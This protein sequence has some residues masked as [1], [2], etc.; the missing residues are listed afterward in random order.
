MNKKIG[1]TFLVILAFLLLLLI[2]DS[3]LSPFLQPLG[4]ELKVEKFSSEEDF[5]IYLEEAES[6]VAGFFGGA[7]SFTVAEAPDAWEQ[8]AVPNLALEE[9]GKGIGESGR[10]S[11]TTVQVLGIDEPDIVKTDGE[12]I[13]F[14]PQSV[15]YPITLWEEDYRTMTGQ[16]RII[17][18][19]PPSELVQ[20]DKIEKSGDLLLS[21]SIL[22]IFSGDTMF[23][24]D[25]SDSQSPEKKWEV[26]FGER[27]YLDGARLYQ[28]KIYLIT[29]TSID[30]YN[31]C[32]IYPLG[33]L[34]VR[35]T[36]IY[37]PTV[38]I[39]ADITY[40]AMV[41]DPSSGEIEKTVSFVGTSSSSVVYM[42]ENSLYLVY[43]Y[44]QDF[45]EFFSDFIGENQDLFPAQLVEKMNK[46]ETYDISDMAKMTE[47]EVIFEEYTNS[48]SR[49]DEM[50][51][52]NELENRMDDYYEKHKRSFEKTG[53]VKVGLE[54][55]RVEATGSVP[56]QPL[57]QF[58][59]DEYKGYLR[60]ATTAGQ[61][62]GE[63]ANDVYILDDNLKITGQ[64]LDLGLT[65][66]IYSVRFIQDRGYV[67][68]FRQIDPFYVL[69]LSDAKNPELKGELK[70]P[71]Y[72]SYLHPVSEGKILGIGKE[73][74]NVK[75]SLFD[76]ADPEQPLEAAKYT[77]KEYWSDILDT[78]HAFLLDEKHQV[79]FLPGS[80]GGYVFSY[81]ED[82]LA[83]VRA[84]SDISARRAV[85]IDDYLY[86]IGDNKISVLDETSWEKV[87]ELDLEF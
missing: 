3:E 29:K 14:S 45:F 41:L 34:E 33:G 70:I 37:Y 62:S 52:E 85:Y 51:L 87:K 56:G 25:V 23:G 27:S 2:V 17:K 6:T 78:H 44:Y 76:V 26:D 57:N 49:D 69:D 68:T 60:M 64:V 4:S 20:K 32:P 66:R 83:M 55:F 75:V 24:Y 38:K 8:P 77:L 30:R 46:L 80:R 71:G 81:K 22:V 36:D 73:G 54:S 58:S 43:S 65:E 10:V 53:I 19:F 9:A 31:P 39:P 15:Y 11:Q 74:S 47:F 82:K 84:V 67:V 28:G 5:K 63:S 61:M 79:F 18:A 16:T 21:G 40:N 72:S 50:K 1:L 59:L 48:L 7:R 13:Y 42:S 86:I 35:C 12:N